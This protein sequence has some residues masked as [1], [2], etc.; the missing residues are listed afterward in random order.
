MS[1][2]FDLIFVM[3]GNVVSLMKEIPLSDNVSLYDF[4]IAVFISFTN[5]IPIIGPYIGGI[6]A[7]IIGFSMSNELGISALIVVVIVQ[8]IES[9]FLQPIIL[10]NV[11]SLHPLE[12]VL[13]ISLFGSLFGVVGMILSPILILAFKL[14]FL[15]IYPY[16]IDP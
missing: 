11:I 7:V 8:L 10:K 16:R 5:L 6:P 15:Q 4:S 2:V 1:G 3:F 14:R 12:G 9:V 13:G